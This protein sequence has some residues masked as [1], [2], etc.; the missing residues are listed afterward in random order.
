MASFPPLGRRK[1]LRDGT[2]YMVESLP[3]FGSRGGKEKPATAEQENT[4]LVRRAYERFLQGEIL[5]VLDLLPDDG[6]WLIPRPGVAPATGAL[7]HAFG[8]G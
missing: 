6:E 2:M 7:S 8:E 3:G 4:E 1:S 5:A